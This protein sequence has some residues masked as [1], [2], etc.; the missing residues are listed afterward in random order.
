MVSLGQMTSEV[1]SVLLLLFTPEHGGGAGSGSTGAGALTPEAVDGGFSMTRGSFRMVMVGIPF[2]V[3]PSGDCTPPVPRGGVRTSLASGIHPTSHEPG[4][5][6]TWY[7][8]VHLRATGWHSRGFISP[9]P[10]DGLICGVGDIF[11][12]QS[13]SHPFGARSGWNPSA[14]RIVSGIHILGFVSLPVPI[15]SIGGRVII[16]PAE[17]VKGRSSEFVPDFRKRATAIFL[18]ASIFIVQF[19]FMSGSLDVSRVAVSARDRRQSYCQPA[20][21]YPLAGVA[22]K[23]T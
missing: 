1:F 20:N 22:T 7:H 11:A 17:N 2:V 3:T 10:V 9:V 5:C 8:T 12:L 18:A 6:S 14:Q 4:V 19:G 15:T 16:V 21:T 13:I 23:V